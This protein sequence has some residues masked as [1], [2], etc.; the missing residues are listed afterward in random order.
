M[1]VVRPAFVPV[2]HFPV[3]SGK[4]RAFTLPQRLTVALPDVRND[5]TFH[6]KLIRRHLKRSFPARD[7][8]EDDKRIVFKVP[9][10]P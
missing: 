2:S 3:K 7:F 9:S 4:T 1:R 10:L 5:G 6:R 8:L